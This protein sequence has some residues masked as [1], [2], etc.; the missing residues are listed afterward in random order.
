MK[1]L[2]SAFTPQCLGACLGKRVQCQTKQLQIHHSCYGSLI[3]EGKH[4]L[5]VSNTIEYILRLAFFS[6]ESNSP[7]GIEVQTTSGLCSV[8][9]LARHVSGPCKT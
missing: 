3:I 9:L 5:R 6:Q 1:D 4:T 8:P 7:D 2:L